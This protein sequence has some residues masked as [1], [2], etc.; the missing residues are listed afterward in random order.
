MK[1]G[2]INDPGDCRGSVDPL[3]ESAALAAKRATGRAAEHVETITADSF[4][5]ATFKVYLDGPPHAVAVQFA[6]RCRSSVSTSA[7][8]LAHMAAVLDAPEVLRFPDQ[9]D[10]GPAALVTTWLEGRSLNRLLPHL[11]AGDLDELART[12]AETANLI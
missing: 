11:P 6:R 4:S 9:D 8:L 10:D 2:S 1:V 3:R 7:T 12:V 5:H